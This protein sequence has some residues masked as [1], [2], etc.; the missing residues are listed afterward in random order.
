MTLA[1]LNLKQMYNN[2]TKGGII[3]FDDYFLWAGQRK[4][5]DEFFENLNEKYDIVK[6][7]NQTA[8]IIKKIISIYLLYSNN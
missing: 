8:A 5:T 4:A 6:I 1:N 7:N 3:I 2:V